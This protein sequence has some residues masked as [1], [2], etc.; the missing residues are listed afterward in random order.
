MNLI[1][2]KD[3]I[4]YYY[5]MFKFVDDSNSNHLKLMFDK[6]IGRK[7]VSQSVLV[8]RPHREFIITYKE[9]T[10]EL[11]SISNVVTLLEFILKN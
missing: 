8:E 9:D 11:P 2:L 6:K 7:K 1:G 5:P 3:L 4:K 10:F